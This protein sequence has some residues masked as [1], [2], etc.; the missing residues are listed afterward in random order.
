MP[1]TAK[2]FDHLAGQAAT[3]LWE[4]TIKGIFGYS[5]A[6][7]AGLRYSQGGAMRCLIGTLGVY[8][9]RH[10]FLAGCLQT[11]GEVPLPYKHT[12]YILHARGK[13]Y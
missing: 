11:L 10:Q 9:V 6:S 7:G 13:K 1:G 5:K 3:R 2:W 4:Q 12:I 8:A